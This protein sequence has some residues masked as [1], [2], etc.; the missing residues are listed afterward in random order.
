MTK[1]SI[2]ESADTDVPARTAL[3]RAIRV[4]A[5]DVRNRFR[6]KAICGC[7]GA[8]IRT[9]AVVPD[10][11]TWQLVEALSLLGVI[12]RSEDAAADMINI[13]GKTGPIEI[14]ED[15]IV[16][17][18]WAQQTL[19]G[20]RSALSGRPDLIVTSSPEPPNPNNTTR[21]IEAKCVRYLGTRTVRS[22]FGKAHDLRVA[23]YLIWSFYTPAPRV[24]AGARGLGIDLE[25]LG[26]DTEHRAELVGS[27]EVLIS[28]VV[29]TQEQARRDQRCAVMLDEAS[30]QS[31]QKLSGPPR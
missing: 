24:V 22:E 12:L 1:E 21:I 8:P 31:R 14:R 30:Q 13:F 16:R 17:Q 11:A 23:T 2:P 7:D 18:L 6:V 4:A 9:G 26:F 19:L 29:Y 3:W 5:D 20:E 25:A 27:P 10:V 15:G 28:R